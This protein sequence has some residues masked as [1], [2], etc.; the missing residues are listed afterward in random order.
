MEQYKAY[1]ASVYLAETNDLEGWNWDIMTS[2]R[3]PFD[4]TNLETRDFFE[5]EDNQHLDNEAFNNLLG[6]PL[7]WS[8]RPLIL[9]TITY[10][11]F[12]S[13]FKMHVS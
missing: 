6:H 1:K 13:S 12:F 11:I 9:W 5:D 3:P 10:L 7:A 4:I 2:E 8:R